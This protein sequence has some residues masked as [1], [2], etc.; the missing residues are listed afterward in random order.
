MTSVLLLVDVQDN[1]LRPPSPVPGAHAVG[2][3]IEDLLGRARAAGTP[4]VH[5][6]NN[7]GATDPDAPRT[8]GWQL[9][10]AVRAGEHVVD[11]HE[12]DAFAGTPLAGLLPEAAH[13]VVAGMQSESCVRET[14]LAALRRGHRVT[15]VRDAHATYD[16]T[17]SAAET[18]RR[19]EEELAVAGVTVAGREEVRFR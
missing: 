15:L 12:P 9:V 13:V 14:S 5:V 19:V 6:R 16:G 17:T 7:G 8:P 1:M 10:H 4:V 18:S 2:A 3:A 11:K